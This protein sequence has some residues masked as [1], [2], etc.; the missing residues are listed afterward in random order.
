M[1]IDKNNDEDFDHENKMFSTMLIKMN[2]NLDYMVSNKILL[3][4]LSDD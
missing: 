4:S 3:M 1:L 2:K